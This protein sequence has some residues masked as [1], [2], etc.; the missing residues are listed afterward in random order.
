LAVDA[1]QN[2]RE[3]L[4]LAFNRHCEVRGSEQVMHV[5]KFVTES[6]AQK[7]PEAPTSVHK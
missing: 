5:T 7:L 6:Q 4:R 1:E 3:L 2:I